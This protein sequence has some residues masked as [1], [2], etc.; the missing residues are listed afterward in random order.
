MSSYR[1]NF[2]RIKII[3]VLHERWTTTVSGMPKRES[4]P[5]RRPGRSKSSSPKA[6]VKLK[7]DSKATTSAKSTARTRS[8]SPKRS[9]SQRL[10]RS[11]KKSVL[12]AVDSAETLKRVTSRRYVYNADEGQPEIT[13]KL[14]MNAHGMAV[15]ANSVFNSK[16]KRWCMIKITI[17][18]CY[19]LYH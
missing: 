6:E 11:V 8:K 9:N 4:S 12:D 13:E 10:K 15:I 1:D 17:T 3:F 7:S 14:D 2:G 16:S 18:N 19:F 5:K